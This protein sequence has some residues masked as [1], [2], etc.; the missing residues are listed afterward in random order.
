MKLLKL[1]AFVALFAQQIH[2]YS[3][4]VDSYYHEDRY[5]KLIFRTC[6]D[7]YMIRVPANARE[8]SLL[9]YPIG[10]HKAGCCF[11]TVEFFDKNKK[12]I[13]Y[14][15]INKNNEIAGVIRYTDE[16][17]EIQ[18]SHSTSPA[19]SDILCTDRNF[20]IDSKGRLGIWESCTKGDSKYIGC[21][22]ISQQT[23]NAI[24]GRK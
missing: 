19:L 6:A 4:G 15:P 12:Q 20:V 3:Y 5:I 2:S 14:L 9:R 18:P 22:R 8:M 24:R 16:N 21:V 11:H 1:F 23:A 10:H 17:V 7:S 13:D